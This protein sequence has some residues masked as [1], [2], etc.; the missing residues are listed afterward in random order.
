MSVLGVYGLP[1]SGKTTFLASCAVHSLRGKR[2]MG[3]DPHPRVFTTFACPGCFKLDPHMIGHVDMS[4]SL[5]LIDEISSFFDAR[6]WKTFPAETRTWFQFHR[7]YHCD[8]IACSQSALDADLRIRNL[9]ER[10]YLLEDFVLGY[11]VVKRIYRVLGVSDGSL[12]DRYE[13]AAPISWK[14]VRR[15]TYYPLFDSYAVYQELPTSDFEL[16]SP[17]SDRWCKNPVLSLPLPLRSRQR[18]REVQMSK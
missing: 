16:W 10:Y 11:S 3:I 18:Q 14:L 4:D 7:H 2:Y 1:G 6:E 9:F 13:V 8:V 5:L 15:K 17:L 12:S